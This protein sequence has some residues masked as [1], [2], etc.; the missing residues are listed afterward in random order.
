MLLIALLGS[1]AAS[2]A[3]LPGS[4]LDLDQ[5]KQEAHTIAV[6][7]VGKIGDVLG[8]SGRSIQTWTELR[9]S[10]MLKGEMSTEELNRLPL[11]V[12]AQERE[13]L[14]RTGEEF[15][16]FIG[17]EES[18][19]PI[20]KVLAN[21]AENLEAIRTARP[22]RRAHLG[23]G[24]GGGLGGSL[25][26]LRPTE[27]APVDRGTRILPDPHAQEP[28]R[29]AQH[30]FAAVLSR[31]DPKPADR[32]AHFAWVFR[33]E[34]ARR[35]GVSQVGW[36]GTITKAQPRPEG[37]WLLRVSVRPWLQGSLRH[38]LVLD[39]V[40]ETYEFS[41]GKIRLVGSDAGIEKPKLQRFPV[42][43]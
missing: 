27:L 40:E 23:G 19:S 3:L 4:T 28:A 1:I 36:W 29:A 9:P 26:M 18:R 35:Y 43:Y 17:N 7:S 24:I 6:A 42:A 22:S 2:Q 38:T 5:A 41:G 37:G 31:A 25:S 11:S 14:P 20:T 8:G 21:T 39:T 32:Q 13:R 30:E 33:N 15:I 16:F 34:T 10:A 12:C